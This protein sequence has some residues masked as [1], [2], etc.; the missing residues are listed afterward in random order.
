MKNEEYES[1]CEAI[2]VLLTEKVKDYKPGQFIVFAQGIPGPETTPVHAIWPDTICE[3]L[4]RSAFRYLGN[5]LDEL[6]S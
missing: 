2:D 3:G 5:L 4:T 1:V 6:A